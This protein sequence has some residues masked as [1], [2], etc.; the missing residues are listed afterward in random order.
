MTSN[1]R[2]V[3]GLLEIVDDRKKIELQA[4]T[5]SGLRGSSRQEFEIERIRRID[6]N[7]ALIETSI[8]CSESRHDR[9]RLRMLITDYAL[10]Y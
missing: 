8:A 3:D 4:A 2:R 10:I 9:L 6:G 5:T 7:I 1:N